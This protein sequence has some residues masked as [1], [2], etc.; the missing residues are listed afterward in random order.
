MT[1]C[2]HDTTFSEEVRAASPVVD[3]EDRNLCWSVHIAAGPL[4]VVSSVPGKCLLARSLIS[5]GRIVGEGH[6]ECLSEMQ[7][8]RIYRVGKPLVSPYSG[9]S[10]L[11]NVAS[12]VWPPKKAEGSVKKPRTSHWPA[13]GYEWTFTKIELCLTPHKLLPRQR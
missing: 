7:A 2:P 3:V 11:Q 5:R 13:R 8:S 9:R 6:P 1:A 12:R 10:A 4:F